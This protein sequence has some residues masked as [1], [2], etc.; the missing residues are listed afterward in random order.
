LEKETNPTW[1]YFKLVL[2]IVFLAELVLFLMAIIFG[3]LLGYRDALAACFWLGVVIAGCFAIIV[4]SNVLFNLCHKLIRA[5][6][7]K[8]WPNESD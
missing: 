5:V 8:V 1:D 4:L 2:F 3:R 6:M 7:I